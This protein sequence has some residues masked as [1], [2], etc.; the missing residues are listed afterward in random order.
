MNSPPLEGFSKQY[1]MEFPPP[2][3]R[4]SN[5]Q[6]AESDRKSLP[7]PSEPE[8]MNGA[9]WIDFGS[10]NEFQE[11]MKD[12][13][14]LNQQ[15]HDDD[16]SIPIGSDVD[17]GAPLTD[18]D[19]FSA[20]QDLDSEWVDDLSAL[21]RMKEAARSRDIA[22]NRQVS[23]RRAEANKYVVMPLRRRRR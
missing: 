3:N 11:S 15:L 4:G 14:Q 20:R 16:S 1:T 9:N 8:L 18:L 22:Q 23:V 21:E 17:L 19:D 5:F 12:S 6:A 10:A 13:Q 7:T 2:R